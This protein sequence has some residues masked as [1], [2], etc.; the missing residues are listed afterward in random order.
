MHAPSSRANVLGKCP[1]HHVSGNALPGPRGLIWIKQVPAGAESNRGKSAGENAAMLTAGFAFAWSVAMIPSQ[2]SLTEAYLRTPK[3]AALAGI[4]FSVLLFAVFGLMR[5]SVPADPFEQGAWLAG[6]TTYVTLAMNLVPFAGV[7]F[8][9]F[10]GVLRDRLGAR[11]D[12]FFATVFLGSG[13]LLLAMLF[14]AAAVVGAIII[15]FHAAPGALMHSATFHFGRGLA[16]GMI[17]IY[18]AKT[19][20]V[21][22]IT[23]STIAV[24]TR[25]TPRW[26]AICG[27][28]V[29][30]VLIFGSGYVDGSL[31]VFPL[32][33]LLVSASILWDR[34]AAP[35]I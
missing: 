2:P 26:L 28:V 31:L 3:A 13:F 5:L 27:Y 30:A 16:Y 35:K 8:L 33:V 32:W 24:Y 19:A 12:Q 25:L 1:E 11:E 22:M 17:N 20:A 18:L 4:I 9:W 10:V 34:N 7:A 23:T 6:D 21:F 15:A 29:A 14:A